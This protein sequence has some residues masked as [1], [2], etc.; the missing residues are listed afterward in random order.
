MRASRATT[1][2]GRRVLVV[3]PYPPR[4]DGIGAHTRMLAQ[5][6]RDSGHEVHVVTHADTG[7]RAD[8]PGIHVHRVLALSRSSAREAAGLVN[9]LRPQL[10]LAQFAVPA[11]G[12]A[13]FAGLAAMDAARRLGT[14]TVVTY[15]E[16]VRELDLLRGPGVAMYRA[17]ARR[18]DAHVAFSPGAAD[19]LRTALG[20]QVRVLPLGVPDLP[21]PSA[22]ETARIRQAYAVDGATVLALG[23]THPDKGT[24]LLV[25]AAALLVDSSQPVDLLIAGAVRMRRG[26]LRVMEPRD[27]RFA[28]RLA[29]AARSV[30]GVRIRG[31]VPD[32][33][34]AP[35][36]R[37]V[38]ALA[39]P[40]RKITQSGVAGLA[41]A[42]GL[43]CV[44]SDLPGLR[45]VLGPAA[46][47]V[48]VG[49][50]H[51]LAVQLRQVSD[52]GVRGELSRQARQLARSMHYS[53]VAHDL[54]LSVPA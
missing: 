28:R 9:D 21:P 1:A 13:W 37:S 40:Y 52:G 4:P 45:D 51:Q 32:A 29:T 41:L 2:T 34:L 27:R 38:G 46:L 54:V 17:V 43:P 30:P 6:W 18:A 22:G 39:L 50:A 49:D 10:A 47:Y 7:P 33:D 8:G 3:S 26:A 16:A 25:E 20:L 24:D 35:L 12:T 19:A 44:C 11:L 36:L 5:A 53:R 42:A 48:P 31:F 23:F 15:H 14:P